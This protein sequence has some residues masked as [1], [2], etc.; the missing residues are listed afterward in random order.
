MIVGRHRASMLVHRGIMHVVASR[1]GFEVKSFSRRWATEDAS[2]GAGGSQAGHW[3]ED[4]VNL[5]RRVPSLSQF[6]Y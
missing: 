6:K 3:H 2:A 5:K 4:L 1:G